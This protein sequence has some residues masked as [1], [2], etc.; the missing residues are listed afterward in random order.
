MANKRSAPGSRN[1]NLFRTEVNSL[2]ADLGELAGEPGPHP[3]PTAA[4]PDA[5][6]PTADALEPV[7]HATDADADAAE[8]PS[9]GGAAEESPAP[10]ES[11]ADVTPP[12]ASN[13][14]E[15]ALS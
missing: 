14:A 3:P 11:V 6:A 13:E 10:P 12:A 8:V 9:A 2:L 5:A 4:P 7:A 15:Q 1:R